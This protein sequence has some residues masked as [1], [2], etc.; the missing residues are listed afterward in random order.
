MAFKKLQEYNEE[1]YGGFFLLRNDGDFKDVIFLYQNVDDVLIADTHYIK[2]P[3]YSGYVHCTGRG[4]PVCGKGIRVQTKLFIPIYDI[5][6]DEVVF[7]DRGSRFEQQFMS[8]VMLKYPNPSEVVYRITRHGETG[9]VDTTYSM[10]AL[11]KNTSMSYSKILADKNIK[12]PDY[13]DIVC[14]SYDSAQLQRMLSQETG[15]SGELSAYNAVPRSASNA[16][17][18]VCNNVGD[19][20]DSSEVLGSSMVSPSSVSG[21]PI[22]IPS[23]LTVPDDVSGDE[24]VEF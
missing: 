3:E 14:R 12:L 18:T 19:L 24:E 11:A 13:Y 6:A 17:D 23:N 20:P 7:W 21:G 10:V 5:E 8:D 9:S 4:C 22:N 2:T 16:S 15:E 1:R